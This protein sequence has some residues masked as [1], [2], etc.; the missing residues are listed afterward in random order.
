MFIVRGRL[1]NQ[2]N[3]GNN[4]AAMCCNQTIIVAVIKSF[5]N[6][7]LAPCSLHEIRLT[8]TAKLWLKILAAQ[9]ETYI[10]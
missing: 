2:H 6:W 10:Q 9:Q 3:V 4:I 1:F 7:L 5:V 8:R